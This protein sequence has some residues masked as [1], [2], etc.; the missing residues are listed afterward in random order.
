MSISG[1]K[2]INTYICESCKD[3]FTGTAE[4]AF[5]KGWDTPERFLSHCTC[6]RCT[7]DKTAWWRVVAMKQ[8]PT[9]EDLKVIQGHNE[10]WRRAQ[11]DAQESG[12][13]G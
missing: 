7:I 13:D 12:Q 8:Q 11:E 2:R 9:N 1:A 3:E 6:R 10:V 5:D 4:Q